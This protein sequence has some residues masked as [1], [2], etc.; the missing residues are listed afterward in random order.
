ML[1][2]GGSAAELV[3]LIGETDAVEFYAPVADRAAIV[4]EHAL[5]PGSG[6]V[7]AR[8][9][10]DEVWAAINPDSHVAPRGAVFIDLLES[11]DPRARREALRALA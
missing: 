4:A 3:G 10:P 7:T 11:E 5:T 9:V 2:T 8:W 6:S 1:L